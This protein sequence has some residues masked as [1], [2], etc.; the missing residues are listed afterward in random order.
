MLEACVAALIEAC[1]LLFL[2]LSLQSE[3]LNA[4][5]NT[6]VASVA[7]LSMQA[8]EAFGTGPLADQLRADMDRLPEAERGKAASMLATAEKAESQKGVLKSL[9][10]YLQTVSNTDK[11]PELCAAAACVAD[12]DVES[13][14]PVE[15][16]K[17]VVKWM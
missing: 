9:V 1:S 2:L 14:S 8:F 4:A 16:M 6:A 3:Q 11:L 5:V 7:E 12:P 15:P 17:S 10:A 13:C